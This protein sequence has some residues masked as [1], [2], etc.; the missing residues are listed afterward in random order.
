MTRLSDNRKQPMKTV[1]KIYLAV[2]VGMASYVQ[3]DVLSSGKKKVHLLELYTSEGCS[4][5]PPADA[6]LSELKK[7]KDLFKRFIPIAWHVDYWDYI[8]WADAFA[9]PQAAERQR[10]YRQQGKSRGVY[11]PGFFV[12]GHE[13][14]SW[15]RVPLLNP[16]L[17]RLDQREQTADELSLD[18]Q[19]EHI[20]V[21]YDASEKADYQVF[22][23]LLSMN[24]SNSIKAGENAGKQLHHDFIVRKVLHKPLIKGDKGYQQTLN[25]SAT[26]RQPYDAIVAWVQKGSDLTPQQSVGGY[27]Q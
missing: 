17:D 26:Q 27:L 14:R 5:C 1:F 4:S 2:C 7:D 23:A 8:G 24:I 22:I 25:Y 15:F 19:A 9:L 16:V 18:I 21:R 11:T 6:W 3:A 10:L 20:L 12:S 13:W